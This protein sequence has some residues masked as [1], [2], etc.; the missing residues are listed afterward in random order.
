LSVEEAD[1]II[2]LR[3]ELKNR[4]KQTRVVE[5][6]DKGNREKQFE[7][8]TQR[9]DKVDKAVKQTDED[10]SKKLDLIQ[11]KK[12]LYQVPLQ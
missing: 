12:K 4:I 10:L 9:L 11:V 8:I 7:P 6:V 1:N 3:E 2:Q 5:V